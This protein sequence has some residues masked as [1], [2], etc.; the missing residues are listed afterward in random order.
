MSATYSQMVQENESS[1]YSTCNFSVN[2]KL[3]QNFKQLK[4]EL[5]RKY[6]KIEKMKR[7]IPN[8][9]KNVSNDR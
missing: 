1:L 6:K 9:E 5:M 8:W 4:N 2:L 7:L 3:L